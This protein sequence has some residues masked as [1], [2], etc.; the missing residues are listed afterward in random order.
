[1]AELRAAL[2]SAVPDA[3]PEVNTGESNDTLVVINFTTANPKLDTEDVLDKLFDAY[4]ANK[5]F[6]A[7]Y[8]GNNEFSVTF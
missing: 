7:K 8:K 2:K 5:S 4:K 1:M 6:D 3:L